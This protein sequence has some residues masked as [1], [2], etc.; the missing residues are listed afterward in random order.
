MFSLAAGNKLNLFNYR[1]VSW[2]LWLE[3]VDNIKCFF[4]SFSPSGIYTEDLDV[5]CVGEDGIKARG[6][7]RGTKPVIHSF[8]K[9]LLGTHICCRLFYVPRTIGKQSR[10]PDFS[11]SSQLGP[12]VG[13]TN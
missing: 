5:S 8:N 12:E 2:G 9:Y 7:V 3:D 1:C 6:A 10:I 4:S 11:G 13:K